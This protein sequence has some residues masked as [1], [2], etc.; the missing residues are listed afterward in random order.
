MLSRIH[1]VATALPAGCTGASPG[2][3]SHMLTVGLNSTT[4]LATG[5][6]IPACPFPPPPRVEGHDA[7]FSV[8]FSCALSISTLLGV[9]WIHLIDVC[10]NT[11]AIASAEGILAP[12]STIV[13]LLVVL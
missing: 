9:P 5:T 11:D 10:G 6:T 8:C 13:V 12:I 2:F 3:A 1:C 7:A 4:Y